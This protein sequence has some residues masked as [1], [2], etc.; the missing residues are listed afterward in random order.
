MSTRYRC[1]VEHERDQFMSQIVQQV[2]LFQSQFHPG[3]ERLT[4]THC[5]VALFV[6]VIAFAGLSWLK[7]D[8]LKEIEQ[9]IS[10]LDGQHQTMMAQLSKL[11]MTSNTNKKTAVKESEIADKE[12]ELKARRELLGTLTGGKYGSTEG[13]SEFMLAL[14]RQHVKG[15]WITGLSVQQGGEQL[16]IAGSSLTPELAPIYLQNLSNEKVFAGKTFD[17]MDLNRQE[18][19]AEDKLKNIPDRIDFIFRSDNDDVMQVGEIKNES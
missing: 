8:Q 7:I 17:V 2:N 19:S 11:A 10:N 6:V 9:Q 18:A 3:K 13:F 4:L 5:L 16:A 15:A 14:S 1:S 12:E